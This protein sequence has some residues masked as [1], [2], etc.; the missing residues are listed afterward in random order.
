MPTGYNVPFEGSLLVGAY[1]AIRT[2]LLDEV[3]F[4]EPVP[5][6]DGIFRR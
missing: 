1:F 2:L 3:T 4:D 5:Q 6:N